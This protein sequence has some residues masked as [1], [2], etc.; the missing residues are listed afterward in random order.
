MIH[1]QPGRGAAPDQLEHEAMH[2]LEDRGI[3]HPQRR[4]LVDVEEAAIVDLFGRD[5]PV[6][7][8]VRLLIQ[9]PIEQVEAARLTRRA[10]EAGDHA[11]E[12]GLAP[13]R[14]TRPARRGGA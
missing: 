14:S 4:E 10:I 9:Q 1:A 5:P 7:Q 2:L 8:P 11:V 6:R 13:S 3:F 12:I